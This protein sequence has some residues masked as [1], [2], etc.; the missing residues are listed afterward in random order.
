MKRIKLRGHS[1]ISWLLMR[2]NFEHWGLFNLY[3]LDYNDRELYRNISYNLNLYS[4]SVQKI[5]QI[6]FK[7]VWTFPESGCGMSCFVYM[8]QWISVS[9]LLLF[10][11]QG[12]FMNMLL[13]TRI[14]KRRF[15]IW[16]TICTNYQKIILM[17]LWL[18]YKYKRYA[19]VSK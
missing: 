3:C 6:S 1:R 11:H 18:Y 12:H 19:D 16:C 4:S 15:F 14:I 7:I 10:Y 2:Y 5:L 13:L 9:F 8:D 17:K